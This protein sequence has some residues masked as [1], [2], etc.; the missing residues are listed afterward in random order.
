ML[1]LNCLSQ[2]RKCIKPYHISMGTRPLGR[3]ASLLHFNS[4][5]GILSSMIL[6][7]SL[8]ISMRGRFGRS[9]NFGFLI[10]ILKKGGVEDLKDFR[11]ISLVDSMYKLIAKVLANKLKK[12]M[13]GLVNMAQNAFIEGRQILDA[14]LIGN[15]VI[16]SI[17]KKKERGLLYK[18]DIEK[19]YDKID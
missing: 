6:W 15:E 7:T 18:L 13:K 2:K 11:P 4:S 16:D 12:V 1:G 17:L 8:K 5:V 3:M 10:L 9:L 14:S 19:T